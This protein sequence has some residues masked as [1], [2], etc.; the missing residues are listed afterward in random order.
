MKRAVA[1]DF[2]YQQQMIYW[3]ERSQSQQQIF[4][5]IEVTKPDPPPR[6]MISVM[7]INGSDVQ[8][9]VTM[10]TMRMNDGDLFSKCL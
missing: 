3:I 1:L 10:T 9:S 5:W 8:V 6:S 2:D 7:H 4:Y